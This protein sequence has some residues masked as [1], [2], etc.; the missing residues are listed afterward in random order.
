VIPNLVTL[1]YRRASGR[2]LRLWIPVLP[3]A[4]VLSPVL[5]LAGLAGLVACRIF[6]VSFARSLRVGGLLLRALP[7]AR[8]EIV[9]GR[10]G[11]LVSVR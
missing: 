2:W 6:G 9:E 3:V 8:F 10:W 4:L 11:L 1:G 7:G 5:L